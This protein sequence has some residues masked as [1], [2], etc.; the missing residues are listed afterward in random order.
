M[1]LEEA[2]SIEKV[3]DERRRADPPEASSSNLG[4]SLG[5]PVRRKHGSMAVEYLCKYRGRAHIHAAWL[6]SDEIAADGRLSLQRLQHYQ[7]KRAA[8][9][10]EEAALSG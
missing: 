10:V 1:R 9:E 6:T 8:G 5:S 4:N 3:L 7:K 2:N